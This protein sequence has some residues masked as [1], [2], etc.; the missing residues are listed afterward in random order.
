MV[1]YVC[2]TQLT[3]AAIDPSRLT[4]ESPCSDQAN[5]DESIPDSSA[6]TEH[7]T[8]PTQTPSTSGT[9]NYILT[10]NNILTRMLVYRY[11]PQTSGITYI[12]LEEDYSFIE[13]KQ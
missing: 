9:I 12:L 11:S 8:D 10:N 3:F 6:A 13:G 7:G 1:Y 4:R 2:N 5:D